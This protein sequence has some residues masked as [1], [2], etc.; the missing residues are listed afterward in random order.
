MATN[1]EM[2]AGVMRAAENFHRNG[3]AL[4]PNCPVSQGSYAGKLMTIPGALRHCIDAQLLFRACVLSLC[5][6]TPTPCRCT[7]LGP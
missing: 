7:T 4:S 2:K 6:V 5:G 1:I 3:I